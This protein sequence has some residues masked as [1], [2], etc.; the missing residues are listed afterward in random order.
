[1]NNKQAQSQIISSRNHVTIKRIRAL[2]DREE[3]DRTGLFYGEGVRFLIE[4]VKHNAQ[5]EM[6]VICPPLVLNV[7]TRML[8]SKLRRAGTPIIEVT[9]EVLHSIAQ[10]DDPQGVGG[11][12]RQKWRTLDEVKLD[13]RLCWVALESVQSPGNLGSMVRTASAV[14]AA[15]F[16]FLRES[17]DVYDPAS[18]RAGM[19]AIFAQRFVRTTPQE[20]AEWKVPRQWRLIGTSPNG[21]TDYR[22][23]DYTSDP[24]IIMLGS[25]RKGLSPELLA[26]CD[27][28][29]SIPMSGK[30]DSLNISVAAGV[31]LY[32]V[33]YRRRRTVGGI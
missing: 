16:I 31:V 9:P 22:N 15:G 2:R 8:I 3:R 1:M 27:T 18:V 29:V 28:V 24:V 26:M 21:E 23:A 12:V 33:Y 30:T 5:I 19:G 25:E 10:I 6:L 4:A 7:A 13:K 11:V 17:V 32:E 14:G 20:L